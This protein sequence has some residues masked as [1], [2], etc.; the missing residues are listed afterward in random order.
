MGARSNGIWGSNQTTGDVTLDVQGGTLIHHGERSYA[1]YSAAYY[2][3]LSNIDVQNATIILEP[4]SNGGNGVRAI[5]AGTGDI[6][7]DV[8]NSTTVTMKDY[9]SYGIYALH[10]GDGDI[11]ADLIGSTINSESTELHPTNQIT[12]SHGIYVDHRGAG[13]SIDIDVQ[14]A[15]VTTQ[16]LLS[17]GI[18]AQSRHADN[19][20]NIDIE[21]YRERRR[22]N[23]LNQATAAC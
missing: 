15:R 22:P 6:D 3:A 20:G 21:S 17:Y 8:T 7:I 16:G 18:Y 2:G 13:G 12:N 19:A 5:T 10:V 4:G 11:F 14:D 1:V 9:G 23:S